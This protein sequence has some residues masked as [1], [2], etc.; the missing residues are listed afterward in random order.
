[1]EVFRNERHHHFDITGGINR[2]SRTAGTVRLT[3]PANTASGSGAG[4]ATHFPDPA[5]LVRVSTV[6]PLAA[7][8]PAIGEISQAVGA[9]SIKSGAAVHQALMPFFIFNQKAVKRPACFSMVTHDA[10]PKI[11]MAK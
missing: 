6:M 9:P 7:F 11:V 4:G 1:M 5:A 3:P 2:F 8:D 10:L